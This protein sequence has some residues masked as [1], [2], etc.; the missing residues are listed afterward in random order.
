MAYGAIYLLLQRGYKRG[1]GEQLV[2]GYSIFM[3]GVTTA[4]YI[5]GARAK[6]YG[7]VDAI[8][9]PDA[10]MQMSCS[11]A[12][13]ILAVMAAVQILCSDLLLVSELS[14]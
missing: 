1:R 7:F 13:V 10:V 8:F 9:D 3:L 12:G 14:C 5:A 11:P 4:W 2:L 6:A